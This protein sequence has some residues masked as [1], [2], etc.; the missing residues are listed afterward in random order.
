MVSTEPGQ[1]QNRDRVTCLRDLGALDAVGYRRVVRVLHEAVSVVSSLRSTRGVE[2]VLGSK[3]LHHF[4]P[5]LVPVFDTAFIRRGVMRTHAY[6]AMLERGEHWLVHRDEGGAGGRGLLE[7]H[8]YFA[9]CISEIALAD[10]R[11][12]TALRER[13][14]Q[15]FAALA[16]H[17]L[18]KRSDSLLWK[19][20]AK[21]AEYCALGEAAREGLLNPP[22]R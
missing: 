4:F 21:L 9:F 5:S 20:D 15:G 3:V 17:T 1:D 6:R 22:R 13:F 2:P 7:F 18:W 14:G 12:L 16:P 11:T 10:R 8:R 19:L